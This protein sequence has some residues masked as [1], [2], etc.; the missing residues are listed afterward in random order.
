MDIKK[1]AVDMQNACEECDCLLEYVSPVEI[2]INLMGNMGNF[3]DFTDVLKEMYGSEYDWAVEACKISDGFIW[4]PLQYS[5]ENSDL[6]RAV[7][8]NFKKIC[9]I[10]GV[11]SSVGDI[12]KDLQ[13][14]EG[15]EKIEFA[16]NFDNKES[17]NTFWRAWLLHAEE[18]VR[19][20]IIG[21]Y[22]SE[23]QYIL[24]GVIT[25][26]DIKR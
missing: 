12:Q 11:T 2:C 17:A 19:L 5:G 21:T 8:S 25:K 22:K 16:F 9:G 3:A 24:V 14:K 18:G 4:I 26:N 6:V 7:S 10:L 23:S 1:L 20:S 15:A 13:I